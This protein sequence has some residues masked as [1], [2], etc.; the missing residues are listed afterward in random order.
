MWPLDHDL[1]FRT[2]ASCA[3]TVPFVPIHLIMQ[4]PTGRFLLPPPSSTQAGRKRRWNARV[5]RGLSVTVGRPRKWWYRRRLCIC[6]LGIA[7]IEIRAVSERWIGMSPNERS[8]VNQVT[9]ATR[10]R[11]ERTACMAR[12]SAVF[13]GDMWTYGLET[14]IWGSKLAAESV[15]RQV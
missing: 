14:L 6:R 1:A 3:I 9:Y 8:K 10:T 13:L 7:C 4:I 12:F 5:W 15:W 2:W 11:R